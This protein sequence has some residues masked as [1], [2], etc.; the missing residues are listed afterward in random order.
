MRSGTDIHAAAVGPLR[1]SGNARVARDEHQRAEQHQHDGNDVA[2]VRAVAV[3]Q[4]PRDTDRDQERPDDDRA[5][6]D[7]VD[8][9]TAIPPA[10]KPS[11]M[12]QS[13]S[14]N[15]RN[16]HSSQPNPTTISVTG[17]DASLMK[18]SPGACDASSIANARSIRAGGRRLRMPSPRRDPLP[19]LLEVDVHDRRDVERQQLRDDEA[20]DDG[21]AERPARLRR[22]RPSASA[23]GRL[24]IS[25]AIV[26]IMI[27][28]KRVMHAWKIASSA[29]CLP[30]AA[31]RSRSRSS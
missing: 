27:G 25:A 17:N 20:A 28:R 22:R 9:Q 1:R 15:S 29:S 21:E 5:L 26:V 6:V 14:G 23:I 8:R 3:V 10:M 4:E 24:P 11:A 7:A 12:I 30:A 2:P 18:H 31:P 19:G 13:T 16:S